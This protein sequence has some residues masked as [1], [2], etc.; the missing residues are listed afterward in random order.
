MS[1]AASQIDTALSEIRAQQSQLANYNSD[2]VG[3]WKGEA[4]TAFAAAFTQFNE[5]FTIV[6]NALNGILERMG[7]SH[8]N[9]NTV[10]AAN[11]Q[12]VSRIASQLN[13]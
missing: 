5:D 7:A 13:R 3:S 4:A 2:L 1:T 9:Y 12:S 6:V 11:Q 10:E 8:T